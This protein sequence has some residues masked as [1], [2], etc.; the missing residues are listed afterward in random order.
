MTAIPFCPFKPTPSQ[1]AF[2]V[3]DTYEA[4]FFGG[5]GTGAT[6]ALLMTALRGVEDPDYRAL[7]VKKTY[8]DLVRPH[9]IVEEFVDW[10]VDSGAVSRVSDDQMR[11][12]FPSGA[13]IRFDHE[14][15]LESHRSQAYQFVG[16]D[17]LEHFEE[18]TYNFLV[19]RARGDIPRL[20]SAAL[21][22]PDSRTKNHPQ[23]WIYQRFIEPWRARVADR[24]RAHVATS[25]DNPYLSPDYLRG[26]AKISLDEINGNWLFD[27]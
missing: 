20:R 22:S 14:R 13:V 16:I 11:F 9:G 17:G 26:L 21:L 1:A 2:V 4:G 23:H 6:T 24:P 19:S 8:T 3:D 15:N 5:A 18:K 7:I 25:T 12:T 10:T 27:A